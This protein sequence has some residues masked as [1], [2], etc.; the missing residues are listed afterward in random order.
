MPR[1]RK[2]PAVPRIKQTTSVAGAAKYADKA[3]LVNEREPRRTTSIALSLSVLE[4]AKVQALR[5]RR[6]VAQVIESALR[7]YLD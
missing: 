6:S 2:A 4:R 3:N 5:E 1:S 7:N